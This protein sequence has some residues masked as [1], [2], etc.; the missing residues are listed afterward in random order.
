MK[1]NHRKVLWTILLCALIIIAGS[2]LLT[3]L[4]NVLAD[5]LETAAQ[6][7]HLGISP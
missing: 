1:S 2:G 3:I 7:A 5:S 6:N 4:I